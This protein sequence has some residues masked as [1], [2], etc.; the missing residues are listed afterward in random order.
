[1]KAHTCDTFDAGC[2]TRC[3]R[4]ATHY[5]ADNATFS[6]IKCSL[7]NNIPIS[8]IQDGPGGSGGGS[9]GDDGKKGGGGDTSD[10]NGEGSKG[11]NKGPTWLWVGLSMG[12]VMVVGLTAVICYRQHCW[13]TRS[14]NGHERISMNM[15]EPAN[16]R[17]EQLRANI[18][19][20]Y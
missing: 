5:H 13:R 15:D 8:E 14:H 6:L 4:D 2:L 3:S 9:S 20:T 17:A 18:L 12:G 1:V 10:D 16:D 19:G 11:N 7:S